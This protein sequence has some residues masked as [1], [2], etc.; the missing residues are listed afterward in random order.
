MATRGCHFFI[1]KKIKN[2]TVIILYL[3]GVKQK[4]LMMGRYR[5]KMHSSDYLEKLLYKSDDIRVVQ[6]VKTDCYSE[7][8]KFNKSKRFIKNK[9]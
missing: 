3:F 6:M 7:I 9:L 2:K 1:S 8:L 5:I 4:V